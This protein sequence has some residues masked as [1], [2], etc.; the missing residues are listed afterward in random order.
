VGEVQPLLSSWDRTH[1]LLKGTEEWEDK[2][3]LLSGLEFTPA[4]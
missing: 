2:R 3:D 1:S 4:R